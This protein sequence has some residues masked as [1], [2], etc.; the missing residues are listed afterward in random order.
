MQ[1]GERLAHGLLSED[2]LALLWLQQ[3]LRNVRLD[4]LHVLEALLPRLFLSLRL[5]FDLLL[6]CGFWVLPLL[7]AKHELV[8]HFLRP[9]DKHVVPFLRLRMWVEEKVPTTVVL[10][11]L[12]P[13]V[14]CLSYALLTLLV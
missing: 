9:L 5:L 11:E 4:L 2:H 10:L 3:A 14:F 1:V 13:L 6:S 7:L 12:I 8:P